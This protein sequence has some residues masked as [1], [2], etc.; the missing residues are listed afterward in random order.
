MRWR[1]HCSNSENISYEPAL[2]FKVL[3]N[4]CKGTEIG[5]LAMTIKM[6]TADLKNEA[7]HQV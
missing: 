2:I 7:V 5:I 4:T 3:D 1:L 6:K